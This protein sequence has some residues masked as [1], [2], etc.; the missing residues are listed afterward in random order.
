MNP[1]KTSSLQLDVINQ[2][3]E[4][5]GSMPDLCWQIT[6]CLFLP[7]PCLPQHVQAH[8][9]KWGGWALVPA[10]Q[11]GCCDCRVTGW[12]LSCCSRCQVL[13]MASGLLS[14]LPPR[15]A[16]QVLH[17]HALHAL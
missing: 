2:I 9:G 12:V 4:Y 10:A 13:S 11:V 3:Q 15:L 1:L 5:Q 7:P 8:H 17:L 14:D 16:G 6:H